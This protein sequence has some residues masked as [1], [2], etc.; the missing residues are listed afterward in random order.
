MLGNL[1]SNCTVLMVY[2][3]LGSGSFCS[4]SV[5]AAWGISSTTGGNGSPASIDFVDML[6]ERKRLWSVNRSVLETVYSIHAEKGFS[7]FIIFFF[8]QLA[9]RHYAAPT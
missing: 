6:L 8:G 9:K 3:F 4:S 2:F 1:A 7:G 5:G